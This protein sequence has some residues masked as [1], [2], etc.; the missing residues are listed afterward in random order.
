M[1]SCPAKPP[2]NN[3]YGSFSWKNGTK[4]IGEWKNNNR[5]GFGTYTW[6]SGSRYVGHYKNDKRHGFGTYTWKMET[7]CW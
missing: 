5:H 7:I 3:C 6:V 4:Y 1:P 2:F